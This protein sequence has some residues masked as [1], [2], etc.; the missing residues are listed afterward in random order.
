MK[1]LKSTRESQKDNVKMRLAMWDWYINS[2]REALSSDFRPSLPL[3]TNEQATGCRVRRRASTKR[4]IH[5]PPMNGIPVLALAT[6]PTKFV[7]KIVDL[8][9]SAL[10]RARIPFMGLGCSSVIHM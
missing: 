2:G 10:T 3:A 5:P 9:R 7:W 8:Y 6:A 4:D 1:G